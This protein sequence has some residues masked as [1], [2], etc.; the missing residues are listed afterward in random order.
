MCLKYGQSQPKRAYKKNRVYI[1]RVT[2]VL[3]ADALL[4]TQA[5]IQI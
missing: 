2:I 1:E 4:S 3:L 5:A